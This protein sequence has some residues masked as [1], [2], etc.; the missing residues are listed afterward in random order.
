M[1]RLA[2]F[3]ASS[4][5]HDP[6]HAAVADDEGPAP[7]R[8]AEQGGSGAPQGGHDHRPSSSTMVRAAS[9]AR[10]AAT[11]GTASGWRWWGVAA[12]WR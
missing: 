3:L 7:A 6:A 4:N 1:R 11:S 10:S 12:N 5:G 2:V 8:E 9:R